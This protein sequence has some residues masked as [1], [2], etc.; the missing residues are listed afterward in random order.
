MTN[1][2]YGQIHCD[3]IWKWP[4]IEIF[5]NWKED[6]MSLPSVAKYDIY[7]LGRFVDVLNGHDLLTSDIDIII[8]GENNIKE[9]EE[10]IYHGVSLGIEKYNVYVDIQWHSELLRYNEL[11]LSKTYRNTVYMH[12]NQWIVNGKVHSDYTDAIQV[13]DNLWSIVS[14]WP[15]WKQKKRVEDGYK[16]Y[17]PVKIN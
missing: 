6:F 15:T 9:I 3:L 5:N 14:P 11:D 16:Y 13:S 1:L 17:D 2:K 7:L 8:I 4:S 12:S 10:I